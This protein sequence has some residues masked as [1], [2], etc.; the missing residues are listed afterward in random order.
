[1]RLC[2][3]T[4]CEDDH[5]RCYDD[6]KTNNMND[7]YNCKRCGEEWGFIPEDYDFVEE[8]YPDTCPLCSMPITQMIHDIWKEEGIKGIGFMIKILWSK[9]KS[10]E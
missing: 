6:V 5:C 8:N 1:M 7:N 4:D 9:L 3:G 10:D 2:Y